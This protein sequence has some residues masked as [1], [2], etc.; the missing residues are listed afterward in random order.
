MFYYHL[1]HNATN[2]GGRLVDRAKRDC[3]FGKIT[4]V[5]KWPLVIFLNTLFYVE[6]EQKKSIKLEK[7]KVLL[8]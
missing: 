6:K 1:L 2:L 4:F 8:I 3:L 5:S 7:S